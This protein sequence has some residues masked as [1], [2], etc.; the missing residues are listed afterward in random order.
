MPPVLP[1]IANGFIDQNHF[2]CLRPVLQ[3]DSFVCSLLQ[4][5]DPKIGE[6]NGALP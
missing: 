2:C 3:H 1:C 6:V 4:H 5:K